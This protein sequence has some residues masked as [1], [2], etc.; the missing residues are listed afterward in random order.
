MMRSL[1]NGKAMPSQC[2]FKHNHN[3]PPNRPH[4]REVD[5][6]FLLLFHQTEV[7]VRYVVANSEDQIYFLSCNERQNLKLDKESECFWGRAQTHST[8]LDSFLSLP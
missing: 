8:C 1:R 5:L 6:G 2:L 4:L 3:H 7:N